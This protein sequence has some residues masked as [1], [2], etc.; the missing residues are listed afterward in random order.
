VDKLRQ[1]VEAGIITAAQRTAIEALEP[2][3]RAF[4]FSLVHVMWLGGVGL[5]AFAL[6]L[7]ALEISSG[8]MIALMWVCLVY[9]GMLG[10]LDFV[11]K[12]RTHLRLFSSLL[13]VAMGFTAAAALAAFLHAQFG[14][15]DIARSWALMTDWHG[16]VTQTLTLP[17]LL[18]GVVSWLVIRWRGF[19]PAWLALCGA[20]V[21]IIV[22]VFFGLDLDSQVAGSVIWLVLSVIGL[23]W[24]WWFDVRAGAN[25]GFWLNK[26]AVMTFGAYIFGAIVDNMWGRAGLW[27]L[28]PTGLMLALFSVYLRRPAGVSMGA[29]SLMVFLGD[30]LD[31]WDNI[32]VAAALLG[33][34]G[35][36]TVVLGVKAHL[37]ENQL[38]RLLPVALRRL[39][40]EARHDPVTFG[41]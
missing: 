19:L 2:D 24:G 9:T 11:I 28:L 31:A 37:V 32:I 20:M 26:A 23:S 34:L 35:L 29:L 15:L 13:V 17:S 16:P 36:G 5:I 18:M 30:W 38:D 21:L 39:R 33:V 14:H 1:A 22:D 6:W 12:G 8:S 3:A 7:L 10:A 41:F 40:P 27:P 4:R 25:H